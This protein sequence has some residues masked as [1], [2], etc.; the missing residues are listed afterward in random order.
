MPLRQKL[1]NTKDAGD[2]ILTINLYN[3]K[4]YLKHNSSVLIRYDRFFTTH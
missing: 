4:P 2:N 3:T 1:N